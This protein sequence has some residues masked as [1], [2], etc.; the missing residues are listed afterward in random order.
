MKLIVLRSNLLEALSYVEKGVGSDSSLP[1]LKNILLRTEGNRIVM[2]GTNLELAITCVFSGKI[3]E[4]G[5][6]T[7]PFSIFFSIIKNL[8]AERISLELKNKK[9]VVTTDNYEATI[10]GQEAKEFPIIPSLHNTAQ[11]VKINTRTFVEALQK[12]VVSAQYSEIRPEISGILLRI[13]DGVV[14]VATDGFRLTEKRIDQ[15]QTTVQME[16]GTKVIIPLRTIEEILRILPALEKQE[17][18]V[19]I[20]IDPTQILF[21]TQTLQAVSRLIDGNFPEY[22]PIIPQNTETEIVISRTELINALKLTSSF[23]GRANDISFILGENKKHIELYSGD[24]SLGEGRYKVSARIKGEGGL[25]LTF[26][27]KYLLDGLRVFDSE[28]IT[29]GVNAPDKPVVIKTQ[30]E[31]LLL[32]VVMPIKN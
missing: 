21:K 18:F 1:I 13:K 22:E 31:P 8:N 10:Q 29:V 7:I 25:N 15:N 11:S 5:E 27:W 6:I 17:E 12:T 14:C 20:F 19:E 24:S 28:E 26:N 30:E 32:Y 23:S 9:I 3:I 2:V 16:E 4:N